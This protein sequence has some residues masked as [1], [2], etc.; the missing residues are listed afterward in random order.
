MP[1]PP[2]TSPSTATELVLEVMDITPA[3]DVALAPN[4]SPVGFV[5]NCQSTDYNNALWYKYTVPVGIEY[6]SVGIDGIPSSPTPDYRASMNVWTESSPGVYAQYRIIPASGTGFE[7]QLCA[8]L[9]GGVAPTT[10]TMSFNIPVEEGETY[11]FLIWNETDP[12]TTISYDLRVYL[13]HAPDGEPQAGD[14]LIPDDLGG[15]PTAVLRTDQEIESFIYPGPSALKY[16]QGEKFA[17]IQNGGWVMLSNASTSVAGMDFYGPPPFPFLAT[18]DLSTW[19]PNS[20]AMDSVICDQE[21]YGY[22]H[23][24][25][26]GQNYLH[27]FDMHDGTKVWTNTISFDSLV[28]IGVY[29]DILYYVDDNDFVTVRRYNVATET[30]LSDFPYTPPGGTPFMG[31]G[32]ILPDG[33]ICIIDF[34]GATVDWYY[35]DTDGNLLNTVTDRDYHRLTQD[36]SLTHLRIWENN[37]TLFTL[38]DALTPDVTISQFQVNALLSQSGGPKSNFDD[39]YFAFSD[40]CPVL[41]YPEVGFVPPEYNRAS[42]I[43][44]L[45]PGKLNDTLWITQDPEATQDV[46]IPE[47]Y[48]ETYLLGDE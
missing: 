43:Y 16:W 8:V 27:K 32:F 36:N 38:V 41:V 20:S 5:S 1:V 28:A 24:K 33:T 22:C 40:S 23:T 46:K 2:N 37:Q 21:Q 29:D 35:Y 25:L 30:E 48:I 14:V 7:N 47:P 18:I 10:F 34:G 6:I 26:T 19:A 3:A 4:M 17:V 45:V 13:T 11:Y 9:T 12:V 15:F 44:K 31:A 39:M 42:G